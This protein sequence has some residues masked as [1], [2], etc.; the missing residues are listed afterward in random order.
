MA[1]PAALAEPHFYKIILLAAADRSDRPQEVAGI[2]AE[3]FFETAEEVN[4]L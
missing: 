2:H 3:I 1:R 4:L